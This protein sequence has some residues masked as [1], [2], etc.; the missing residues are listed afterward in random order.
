MNLIS[1]FILRRVKVKKYNVISSIC[2][3]IYIL[4]FFLMFNG[5]SFG[6]SGRIALISMCSFSL[7]GAFFGLKGKTGFG[8]WL[9]TILNVLA[10]I[11]IAYLAVLGLSIGEA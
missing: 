2:L 4:L 10:F 7:L 5:V 3:G 8:K 1:D 9:L 11:T 6:A